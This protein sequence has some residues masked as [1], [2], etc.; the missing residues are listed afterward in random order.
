V[1]PVVDP[2]V[3]PVVN[4]AG[5]PGGIAVCIKWVDRRPEVD[6]LTGEVV[7][8][9]RTA[10]ASDSDEAALEWALRLGQ[11][12]HRP[13]MA[14]CAG[15][16]GADT[17]MRE[18]LAVGAS[19]AVRIDCAP[20]T[21][22]DI[23]AA[24]LAGTLP[25]NCPL[26]VCGT[27]SLD[28]GSGSVPAFV[29]AYRGAAQALGL[30][31]LSPASDDSPDGSPDGSLGTRVGSLLAERRL[32]GG[33]R[34]RLRIP[35]PA[36]ISVEGGSARLRRAPLAKVLE[37]RSAAIPTVPGPR[38]APR[39]SSPCVPYRPR[40]RVRPAPVS[41]SARERIL[42]LTG[43]AGDSTHPQRLA[44][45][46]PAAAARVLEQLRTWGYLA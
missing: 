33:R 29:A 30:I 42:E 19:H 37:T 2:V 34:E 24:A 3:D 38:A 1:N 15:L 9:P 20:D 22:S 28:R 13:V 23:V 45:D 12:W 35:L 14:L 46:P 11:A 7:H 31:S 25:E 44:L 32:D 17:V 36:V 21:P 4:P 39:A 8:D 27:W 5:P 10:G 41:A 40:A 26:V 43:A 16:A 6:A 18:A